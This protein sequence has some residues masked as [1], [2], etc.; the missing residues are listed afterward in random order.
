M[1]Y[2]TLIIILC[3]LAL[4]IGQN[5]HV[6]YKHAYAECAAQQSADREL[7]MRDVCYNFDDRILFKDTV[8]CDGAERRLRLSL[9]MCAIHRW[10]SENSVMHMFHTMTGSYWALFF[11]I[12]TP[13]LFA[14]YLWKSRSTEL[15]VLDRMGKLMGKVKKTPRKKA[16][17]AVCYR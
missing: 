9:V 8:D 7:L 13:L 1:I 15:A 14:M 3:F 4:L 11:T 17:T 16:E 12:M 6:R 2:P 5:E 10:G